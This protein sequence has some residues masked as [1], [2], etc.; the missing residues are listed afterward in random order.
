MKKTT[1]K[2]RGAAAKLIPAACMLLVSAT[3]LVSSTYAWFTMNKEVTV[4]GMEVRT[5]VG[6]NLLV[7]QDELSS[8]TK[9]SDN[10]FKATDID[11]MH[12]LL[13]PVS[14]VDGDA[15][16]YTDTYNVAGNGDALTDAYTAYNENTALNNNLGGR[17]NFKTNYDAAFQTNYGITG[18]INTDNVAYGYIDY[19]FQLKANNTS[20]SAQNVVVK[21]IELTSGKA[22]ETDSLHAFRAAIFSQD[23]T[24]TA[25]T[26]NDEGTLVTILSNEGAAT[27]SS[28]FTTKS[29]ISQNG[30]PTTVSNYNAA[31]T[32]GSASANATTYFKVV[33]RLWLEGE[34]TNCNN[35]V[36]NTLTDNWALSLDIVMDGTAATG[37][38]TTSAPTAK[39]VLTSATVAST[40]P[41]T[42]DGIAY[43]KIS[44][45]LDGTDIY[46]SDSTLYSDSV[47][48]KLVNNNHN[49]I[50]VTNQCTLPTTARP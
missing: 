44:V 6:D 9:K 38:L 3:T 29:A 50:D 20:G 34:D 15:F 24:T 47:V 32:I 48:Y 13:E 23:I 18:T 40:N 4:T 37:T 17:V 7:A 30:V 33:V 41:V 42:I 21:S 16:W 19:V 2:K 22:G 49:L 27:G 28:Y 12:A 43:Y 39:A 5:Q 46:T 10:L 36:F 14:T 31:A 45:Q 35:T 1:T 11:V 25:P 8:T 26:A